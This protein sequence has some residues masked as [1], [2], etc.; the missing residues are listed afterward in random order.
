MNKQFIGGITMLFFSTM[1]LAHPEH[2]LTTAFAGFAHPFDGL[3]HLLMMLAVGI[4]AAQQQGALSWQL[5]VSF[6]G[7][8]AVGVSLGFL[9]FNLFWLET[10]IASSLMVMG[11][12]LAMNLSIS[13]LGRIIITAIF[14]TLHGLA[15]GI[16]VQGSISQSYFV[17]SG[18]LLA[19]LLIHGIGFLV[20]MQ[21]NLVMTWLNTGMAFVMV[22]VG[23]LFM[24]N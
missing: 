4:W 9:G 2:D 14:A 21:R 17:L 24:F 19:T 12:L 13:A 8:M 22:I 15:H 5:P 16:L 6:L 20:G 23:G 3:D 7:F 1:V 18:I 10:A 11:V